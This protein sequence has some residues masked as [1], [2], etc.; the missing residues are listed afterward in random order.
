MVKHSFG[1]TWNVV[2]KIQMAWFPPLNMKRKPLLN[3][4]CYPENLGQSLGPSL[5]L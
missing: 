5:T 3:H 4:V 1:W 2:K